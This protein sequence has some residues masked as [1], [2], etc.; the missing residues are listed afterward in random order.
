MLKKLENHLN[1]KAT[2]SKIS[3]ILNTNPL[4]LFTYTK[5]Y[6]KTK[7]KIHLS[8]KIPQE[9]FLG[10]CLVI[11]CD[12]NNIV[13]DNE[14]IDFYFDVLYNNMCSELEI[15]EELEKENLVLR[16]RVV[17]E[18]EVIKDVWYEMC[19]DRL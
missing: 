6:Y 18:F 15:M 14:V 9:H 13:V 10:L 5:T 4:Q 11:Y 16:N 17:N 3:S 2:P 7:Y 12:I 1:I 8:T 19:F